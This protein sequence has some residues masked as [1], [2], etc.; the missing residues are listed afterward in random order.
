MAAP[1]TD[2]YIAAAVRSM[3]AA[4]GP[5]VQAEL[6]VSIEDAIEARIEQGE[7]CGTAERAVLTDLGDPEILAAGYAGRQLQLIG[8][9]FY[10]TWWRLLKLLWVIVPVIAMVGVALGQTLTGETP[11]AVLGASV[12]TGVS[13]VVQVAFWV[14]LVFA[15]LERSSGPAP[16]VEWDVDRLP[17][18]RSRGAGRADLIAAL[19]VLLVG[20]GAILWDRFHGLVR[21][22]ST[23]LPILSTDLWPWWIVG[24]LGLM[25]AQAALVV[26][27][28]RRGR[29]TPA[30]ALINT[31]LALAYAIPAAALLAGGH[32][33]NPQFVALV[34][35]DNGVGADS[36][37]TLALITGA[38]IVGFSAWGVIDGWLKTVRDRT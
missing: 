16:L 32:L 21:L 3:P 24:L 18:I 11:G 22:D 25:A 26:A 14:T 4:C 29:W 33:V 20:A 13:A 2:R 28:Y 35:S 12:S 23:W 19:V 34:L 30:F 27:V 15:V 9:R 7:D 8:P 1:L 10:L 38:G 6:E 17:V 36:I 31:G 5:D 37:R